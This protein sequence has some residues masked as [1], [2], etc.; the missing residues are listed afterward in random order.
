MLQI[1]NLSVNIGE[2]N[3]LNR[4][5]AILDSGSITCILGPNGSG[6]TTLLRAVDGI[7]KCEGTVLYNGEDV[8]ALPVKERAKLIAFLP[9]NRPVLQIE[10]G[11]LIE[12]GRFPHMSFMKKLGEKDHLAIENAI[13]LTETEHLVAKPLGK[14]S[15]GEQQRIYIA[16]ALAQETDVLLLDEP[17]THLDLQSQIEILE[18]MKKLKAAGKTVVAVLH[19]LAQAFSVADKILLLQS[20]SAVDCGAPDELIERGKIK[21]AFG[22][23]LIKDDSPNALYP[24]KLLNLSEENQTY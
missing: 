15:G 4:V 1:D 11:L 16:C 24:F 20:G 13:K 2:K 7:I 21:E 22:Y 12:H 3:I 8:L 19:D 10:G 5:C 9:Q 17:T 6:K 23:N 14:M 18:L